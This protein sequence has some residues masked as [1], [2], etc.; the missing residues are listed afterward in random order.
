MSTTIAALPLLSLDSDEQERLSKVVVIPRRVH[1]QSIDHIETILSDCKQQED[2]FGPSAVLH[3]VSAQRE[4][5][6][7]L[8]DDCPAELHP[9]LLSVYSSM[10]SSIGLYC[11]DLDDA[12]SA[13]HYC[14]EARAAAQEAKNVELAIY[15]LS[16]MSHFA[17]WQGRVH[18]GIDY[19]AAAQSLTNK[20]DDVPLT[21]FAAN[22][23]AIAYAVSGQYKECM[24]ECDRALARLHH[25]PTG[26]LPPSAVYWVNEGF[27]ANTQSYCLLRLGKPKEAAATAE[28]GLKLFDT[29][30][31]GGLAFCK[32]RLGTAR[33]LCGEVE[34]AARL[35][36]DGA[37]LATKYRSVRLTSEVKTARGR[38]QPWQ[39]TAAVEELDERL[40]GIGLGI[41]M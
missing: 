4:F 41:G 7:S 23:A 3:T 16:L 18:A 36:G 24:S 20:I 31:V 6:D 22:K 32:L 19:A 34:E 13:M 5:V 33:L 38:L 11:F 28:R 37:L 8:L 2:T 21:I 29:T 9:R 15:A 27:I 39:D 35:I 14:D 17:A 25:R 10:S 30:R 12:A 26:N 1:E 40:R